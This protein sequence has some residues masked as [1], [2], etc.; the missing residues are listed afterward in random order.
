[1]PVKPA[2]AIATSA[3][4]SPGSG[5]PG[6]SVPGTVSCQKDNCRYGS[7]GAMRYIV[8]G[9]EAGSGIGHACAMN[10]DQSAAGV[11]PPPRNPAEP[12]RICMV[13]LGNICRSPT[14]EVVLRDKLRG[15]GLDGKVIVDSAGM[16]DWH[17]NE[18]M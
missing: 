6:A 18:P 11:V 13:C 15:A 4:V 2:P 10:A 1:M 14:A 5:S 17:L 3:S 8:A 9:C 16:G 12:Y 7:A